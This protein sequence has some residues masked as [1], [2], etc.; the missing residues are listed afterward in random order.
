MVSLGKFP[1]VWKCQEFSSPDRVVGIHTCIGNI[2][3]EGSRLGNV[4]VE[5]TAYSL[6][7]ARMGQ[8]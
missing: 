2:D 7:R 8:S 6:Y 3:T 5:L 4:D 1:D